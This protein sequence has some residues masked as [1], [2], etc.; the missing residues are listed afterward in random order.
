MQ[1]CESC[2][3]DDGAYTF[4]LDCLIANELHIGRV[5]AESLPGFSVYD[6]QAAAHRIA[7]ECMGSD[8]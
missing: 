4:C 2:G 1:V 8:E 5:L 6:Y 3:N 7:I